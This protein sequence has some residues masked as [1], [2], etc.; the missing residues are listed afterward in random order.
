MIYMAQLSIADTCII[1]IQDYLEL[2]RRARNNVPS[3]AEGNWNW[4]LR[5]D[6][7]THE[8]SERIKKITVMAERA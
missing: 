7:M 2:D 3:I 8:L 5:D 4:Q 6:Y 1:P